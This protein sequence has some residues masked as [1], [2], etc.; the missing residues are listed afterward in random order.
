MQDVD[1]MTQELGNVDGPQ[2]LPVER[3]NLAQVQD[4]MG[5]E[6]CGPDRRAP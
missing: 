4:M 3:T 2:H 1:R 5:G 6:G